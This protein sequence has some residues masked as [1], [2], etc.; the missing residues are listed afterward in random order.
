LLYTTLLYAVAVSLTKI[1]QIK[2]APEIY[3][4][5]SQ[6]DSNECKIP[7]PRMAMYL[8]GMASGHGKF[9]L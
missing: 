6:P 7:L 4:L 1:C 8:Y 2:I 9:A 5:N 3:K